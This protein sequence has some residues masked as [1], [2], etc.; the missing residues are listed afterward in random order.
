MLNRY[1][2]CLTILTIF[3]STFAIADVANKP[4]LGRQPVSTIPAAPDVAASAFILIDSTTGKVI[5]EKNADQP[6]PPASLTKLMSSYLV[7]DEIESGRISESDMVN[8]SIKAW[9]MDGSR[10]FIKE[11]T[12]VSVGDLL[13][14]VIIQSGNDATVALAEYI[15][16]D[17]I[18][19]VDMMNKKAAALQMT[20]THF[21]DSSGMPAEGH[22]TTARDL[23]KL[24]SAI[25]N[26]H[27]SHFKLYSERS[28]NY[29]NIRQPNRNLLLGRDPSVDGLKTG[30]TEE[31][32][33]CLVASAKR[34]NTRL[35]AVVL[36]TKSDEARTSETQ[37][38]LNY[39][40]RYFETLTLYSN[41]PTVTT[42]QIW[43]GKAKTVNLGLANSVRLTVPRGRSDS[44]VG[45]VHHNEIITAPIKAGEQLGTLTIELDGKILNEKPLIAMELVEE[46]GLFSRWLDK[47]K[48]F[49]RDLFSSKP[50]TPS[51]Q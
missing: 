29:N 39:G 31:A 30:H 15:G 33:Y 50:E 3:S 49:F 12:L 13:R 38:L 40:F 8:V 21:V 1:T 43:L 20:A 7:T 28:F 51:Q 44:I 45:N 27:P 47:I 23:S 6:L 14:G 11:G 37:K 34:E 17:E 5:A 48:L 41:N 22:L 46:A 35:V 2:S 42:A 9:K 16:G 19:F 10:M 24:A 4:T 32:G 36:G 18:S 25:V 26:D